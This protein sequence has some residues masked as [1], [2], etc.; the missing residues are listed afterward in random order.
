MAELEQIEPSEDPNEAGA[1]PAPAS[2]PANSNEMNLPTTD[3]L[4]NAYKK[5]NPKVDLPETDDLWAAHQSSYTNATQQHLKQ[6]MAGPIDNNPALDASMQKTTAGR[7]QDAFGKGFTS[8]F[9]NGNLGIESGSD[10]E[11]WLTQ[12]G[13]INDYMKGQHDISKDF[14]EAFIRPSAIALDAGWRT[15]MG[16]LTGVYEGTTQA[17]AEIGGPAPELAEWALTTGAPELILPHPIAEGGSLGALESE[18]N[19]FGIKDPSPQQ[20]AIREASTAQIEALKETPVIPPDIHEIARTVA[21]DTF[22]RFDALE[23]QKNDLHAKLEQ[24]RTLRDRDLEGVTPHAD[25]IKTVS[26]QIDQMY[27]KVRGIEAKLTNKQAA[28]LDDLKVKYEELTEKSNA[29]LKAD[30]P[31]MTTIRSEL[32]KTD[33]AMRDLS[34]QVSSAYREAESRMPQQAK[35]ELVQ[36]QPE[37]PEVIQSGLNI[38]KDVS[39]KLIKAGR[40]QEESDAAAQ[41]ISEHYKAISEH[42]WAKGTP[43]EIYNRLAPNIKAGKE[44]TY[45]KGKLHIPYEQEAKNTITLFKNAD[46][47]TFLHETGHGWLEEMRGFAAQKDAPTS[48]LKDMDAVKNYLGVKEDGIITNRMHEK[49]ARGFEQ[50]MLKGIAPSKELANVFAK[51]KQWLSKIYQSMKGL[52]KPINE[53]IQ[54]VFDRL[55]SANPERTVVA[56]EEGLHAP[57]EGEQGNP[58]EITPSTSV[59]S[60]G[61]VMP[62]ESAIPEAPEPKVQPRE[63]KR[64]EP[65]PKPPE[66]PNTPTPPKS[67]YTDK[68]GN[69]RLENLTNN[70]DVRQALRDAANDS[71]DFANARSGVIT[72]DEVASLANAMG[73][74]EKEINLQKL[75]DIS[76]EDGIP[77][78][79]RIRAGRKMLVDSANNVVELANKAKNGKEE[80]LLKFA[81]ARQ[82]HLMIAETVSGVT[83]EVG[84]GLRAFRDI[85]KE[86]FNKAEQFTELFQRMTGMSQKELKAMAEKMGGL[87]TPAKIA[88]FIQDSTKPSFGNQILEYWVNGLISGP[89]THTT[90]AIGNTLLRLWE[91]G[92]ETAIASGLNKFYE[93]IGKEGS[94]VRLGEVGAQIRGG[95]KELPTALSAAGKAVKT[96]STTLL[97]GETI[98]AN[99]LTPF[100]LRRGLSGKITNESKK[101]VDL[102]ADTLATVR[103]LKDAFLATGELIKSGGVEGAPLVGLRRSAQGTIPDVQIKGVTLPVGSTLRLPGRAIAVIHSFFRTGSYS[104]EKYAYAYRTA[105]NEGLTGNKFAARIAD[106]A[107]N[108]TQEMMDKF[109]TAATESTLMGSGGQL[110][111]AMSRLTNASV[112]LPLLGETKPL[113]FIDPFVHIGSNI[114]DQ[115]IVQRTPVGILSKSMRDDLLGRNGAEVRDFAQARMLAGTSLGILGGTLYHE[116]YVSDSGP[117]D[118]RKAGV[119]AQLSGVMPHSVRIGD[120]WYDIHRLG[121]LGMVL[122]VG[123]DLAHVSSAISDEDSTKAASMLVHAVSQNILD[124][125]FMRGPSELIKALDDHDR[126]GD[127]YVRNMAASFVPFS[128]GMSQA[129]RAIDPYSRQARS[130]MDAIKAKI[131]WESQTL[132]PRRDIWGQP[133]PN[134]DVLGIPGFSAIYESHV[135]NDPVNQRLLNIGMYPAS[136]RRQILGVHLSDKQYDEYSA[137]AG[138]N[139]KQALSAFI[140]AVPDTAGMPAGEQ[141]EAMKQ[142]IKDSREKASVAIRMQ[143]PEIIREAVQLKRDAR[144]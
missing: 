22:N 93:A 23:V 109:T 35:E 95:L 50:Y 4:F 85:S 104:M 40:P 118:P 136:P 18:A 46:A 66:D 135:N 64:A 111:K 78:A 87:D 49:F 124:E 79:V 51:F 53:D 63:A 127:A 97:P 25:E 131:P 144:K 106:I 31:I 120:T 27:A 115:A 77:L 5:V 76:V 114:I 44:S 24:A 80:E 117:T 41:L 39:D 107:T 61:E 138:T 33:Y 54:H 73:T 132:L 98:N 82:R 84:R 113:K 92:P 14:S 9:D 37:T 96:G 67:A 72:D 89:A 116:G 91:A 88:K 56:P 94:G 21:P 141:R 42:G 137:M 100:E 29:A 38:Q 17:A 121:P 15:L 13:L 60:S 2:M 45:A 26:D 62:G 58:A 130:V 86:E 108:P 19:F 65:Q 57:I 105:A 143:Y 123:A 28:K 48:L 34:P 36:S 125:S 11:K 16:T 142:L 102:G 133:I 7:I 139:A 68:A 3:S 69:I 10:A 126:Y 83:E 81:E 122:S 129:A 110:T 59:P 8:A 43:E 55:L 20:Q 74:S 32:Q 75:R 128:V 70:E 112:D 12:H 90:Y 6:T 30:T 71:K 140:K 134:K 99:S 1:I 103:G 52:G 47:S 101:W 119:Y